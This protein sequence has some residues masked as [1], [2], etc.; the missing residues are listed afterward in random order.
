MSK[1]KEEKREQEY[2]RKKIGEKL[3]EAYLSIP[4]G[5]PPSE[6][7]IKKWIQIADQKRA[8]RLKRKRIL[9]SSAAAV[10][11]CAGV[12]ATC[13]LHTPKAVAG[14]SGEIGAGEQIKN[15]D[16]FTSEKD[17][18]SWVKEDFLLMNDVPEGF[19]V[20]KYEVSNYS[21]IVKDFSIYYTNANA[22]QLIINETSVDQN[23][24]STVTLN[25]KG[26]IERWG[27]IEVHINSYIDE[28]M[29][30]TVY[31]FEYNNLAIT[32]KTPDNINKTDI[33]WMITKAVWS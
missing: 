2:Y 30:S 5:E 12:C 29:S 19:E 13:I 1:R 33:Q 15:V 27:D 18:P 28:N 11:L 4:M 17:L 21:N 3:E 26:V 32:V 14:N 23:N 20:D 31:Y 8:Q 16:I 9:L 22:E 7:T 24:N 25:D 6:E 10:V